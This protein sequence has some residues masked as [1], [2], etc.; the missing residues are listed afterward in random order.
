MVL[1]FHSL[2]M[3]FGSSI[4]GRLRI[5]YCGSC[6]GELLRCQFGCHMGLG[7]VGF[8]HSGVCVW[9][10]GYWVNYMMSAISFGCVVGFRL[11]PLSSPKM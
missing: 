11:C 3:D 8:E 10:D 4:V 9:K 2:G 7:S 6:S 5:V 1:C